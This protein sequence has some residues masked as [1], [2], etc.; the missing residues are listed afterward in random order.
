MKAAGLPIAT[1]AVLLLLLAA[2]AEAYTLQS[3]SKLKCVSSVSAARLKAL[4][5]KDTSI[6]SVFSKACLSKLAV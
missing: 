1:P 2:Q 5:Q 3:Q 6:H 4:S